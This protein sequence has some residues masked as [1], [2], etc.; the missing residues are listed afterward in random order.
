MA[1][2]VPVSSPIRWQCVERISTRAIKLSRIALKIVGFTANQFA[3]CFN[4]VF[5][6]SGEAVVY[7]SKACSF[8]ADQIASKMMK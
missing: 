4:K 1:S 6:L 2:K 8:T 7:F 3:D 5:N